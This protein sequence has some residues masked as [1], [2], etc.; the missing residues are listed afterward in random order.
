MKGDFLGVF[1]DNQARARLLRV[2]IFGQS[3]AFTVPAAAKRSGLNARTVLRELAYLERLGVL[4]K[5]KAA[6]ARKK[7]EKAR[8]KREVK[9]EAVWTI[10]P[11]CK[12]LRALSSFV[13][14]V[15][16]MRHE[17]IVNSLKSSGR[18]AAVVLSGCFMGDLSRPV[19]LIVAA[20]NLNEDRLE[21]A[22]RALEPQFGR[23]I[24]YSAFST[25]EFR[26]RL[27]V[28]DHL[29]R[30]TLDYPHQVLFDRLHLL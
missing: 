30:D 23:E 3:E 14:E 10:D 6:P 13:H 7:G 29:I 27:T 4:K 17:N 19:D 21:H 12:H 22:V 5:A 11:D 25:P 26:Y 24:R 16:P 20:D 18:L 2:F 8:P 28:Q 15:S 9:T 1:M